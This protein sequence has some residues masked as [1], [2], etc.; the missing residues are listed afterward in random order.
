LTQEQRGISTRLMLVAALVLVI[1]SITISS[2]LVIRNSMRSQ[3]LDDFSVELAHSVETFQSFESQRLAALQRE[4]ALLADLPSLK[5]L[6]T[7]SDER[8]IADGAIQFWQVGDNDLFALASSDGQVL[9]AYTRGEPADSELRSNVGGI[10][11]HP[12]K[13]YLL[14]GGRLFEYSVRPLYFGSAATGTLL[15][16]VISG[17][18]IDSAFL[19]QL[20]RSS[21]AEI[22]FLSGDQVVTSTLQPSLQLE[23]SRRPESLPHGRGTPATI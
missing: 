5:A 21:A 11:I 3:V 8:T 18:A 16:Y 17:Y 20:N 14:S 15:G 10:L 19:R 12:E 13:H 4:N 23:L 1:A 6:M 7:T 9:A 22:T 2:L